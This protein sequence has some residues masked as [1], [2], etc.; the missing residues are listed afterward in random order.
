[1]ASHRQC[2]H[3]DDYMAQDS[4]WWALLLLALCAVA[5]EAEH[6]H[7]D[8]HPAASISMG[9]RPLVSYNRRRDEP[10]RTGAQVT[11]RMVLTFYL[12]GAVPG[13]TYR[14]VA[15]QVHR[16]NTRPNMCRRLAIVHELHA[17]LSSPD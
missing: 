12:V 7:G 2:D 4:R 14:A 17:S 5:D 15:E 9:A 13:F 11:S 6:L 16:G 10:A 3:R 8:N 1:V